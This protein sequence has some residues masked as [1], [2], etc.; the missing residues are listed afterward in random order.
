MNDYDY[1]ILTAGS[2]WMHSP[3]SGPSGVETRPPS[4]FPWRLQWSVFQWG[5]QPPPHPLPIFT[6]LYS[7]KYSG[8]FNWI[9]Q[10]KNWRGVGWGLDRSYCLLT[11]RLTVAQLSRQYFDKRKYKWFNCMVFL[12]ED[13]SLLIRFS[14]DVLFWGKF[15]GTA[16]LL[17]WG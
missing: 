14:S 8:V 10:G 1:L 13:A 6:L 15:G 5:V 16:P 7:V 2:I 3:E 11:I 17:L 12:E 9:E 4:F